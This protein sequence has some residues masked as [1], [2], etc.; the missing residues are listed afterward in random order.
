MINL[1]KVLSD[2]E[3]SIESGYLLEYISDLERI[4]VKNTNCPF[5]LEEYGALQGLSRSLQY[6]R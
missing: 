5:G 3:I 4:F 6:F 2:M 1:W